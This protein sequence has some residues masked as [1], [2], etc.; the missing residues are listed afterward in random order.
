MLLYQYL[1]SILPALALLYI[2]V[3]LDRFPEPTDKIIKTFILGILICFP[4]YYLNTYSS[5]YIYYEM[6]YGEFRDLLYD[7]IPG[8][9]IEELL[10]MS[11][12]VFYCSRIKEFDEP[13]DGLVYGATAALGFAVYENIIYVTSSDDWEHTAIIRALFSVPSHSFSGIFLGFSMSYYIFYKK[14]IIFPLIGL[15][16]SIYLHYLW[17]YSAENNPIYL[18][19]IMFVE[20]ILVYILF[21]HL[22]KKQKKHQLLMNKLYG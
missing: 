10:K 17:N 1:S 16:I 18:V 7:L 21:R 20:I 9:V 14:N 12:L 13:M 8:A 2:F 15:F 22:R 19:L 5:D 11:I 6:D 3:T 4:A